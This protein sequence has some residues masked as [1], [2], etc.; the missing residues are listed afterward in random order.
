MARSHRLFELMQVLRRHRRTVSGQTLARELGVSLRTIRRDVVTLQG[1]GADIE[2]EPGLGYILKPGFLLPP[3]AFTEEEIQALVVGAQWVS[4]QTDD[5]FAFAVKNA[6]AKINAVLPLD[7]RHTFDD[8]T[9][10]V[11]A[12]SNLST[13]IDLSEVRFALRDQRK[14]LI[15]L[16]ITHAPADKQIVW[17]IM[18]GF[19]DAKRFLS[20]WCEADNRFRVIAMD[21]IAKLEVLAERYSRNRRQLIKEWRAHE[22]LPCSGSGE[23]C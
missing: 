13:S 7:M 20:A 11:G 23:V 5:K 9:F 10:Y 6:L 16:S 19:I 2:G 1:M 15:T 8:E 4:R 3:L 17:P 14:L 18:L 12:H 22:I 21:D